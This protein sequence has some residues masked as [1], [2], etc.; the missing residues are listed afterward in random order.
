MAYMG[1]RSWTFWMTLFTV[2][3]PFV[4]WANSNTNKIETREFDSKNIRRVDVENLSGRIVVRG[5]NG[6]KSTVKI[7]KI[8]FDKFCEVEIIQKEDELQVEVERRGLSRDG[9]CEANIELQIPSDV[10]LE[11]ANGSG[12]ILVEGTR[13]EVDFAV[14]SGDVALDGRIDDLEGKTGSGSVRAKGLVGPAKLKSGSGDIHLVYAT[15]P[16]QGEI[17]IRAGS[18]DAEIMLPAKTRLKTQ[19]FTGSGSVRNEFGED[20][21]APFR[22]SFKA[23]SGD[24]RLRKIN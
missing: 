5:G 24:L 6:S 13:G 20:P 16:S 22:V 3:S 1:K 9:E 15:I 21:G 2:F 17:E 10:K 14:G 11:L 8:K 18:G 7:E 12:N 4:T 23:G 19:A